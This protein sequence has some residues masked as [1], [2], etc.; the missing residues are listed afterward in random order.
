MRIEPDWCILITTIFLLTAMS[1]LAGAD[2]GIDDAEKA[3]LH[4][5]MRI[6]CADRPADI[7]CKMTQP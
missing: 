3:T 7:N 2:R 4:D 5:R 6:Y 1:F